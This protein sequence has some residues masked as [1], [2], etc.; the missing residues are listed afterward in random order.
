KSGITLR[1]PSGS[2]VYLIFSLIELLPF[3]PV[4][5]SEYPDLAPTVRKPNSQHATSNLS[6]TVIS[7]FTFAMGKIF[8]D[9]TA[10]IGKGILG[11]YERDPMFSLIEEIFLQIPFEALLSHARA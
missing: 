8:G 1:S 10:R 7:F 2:S 3:P 6:E 11:L 9:H 4:A 5:C